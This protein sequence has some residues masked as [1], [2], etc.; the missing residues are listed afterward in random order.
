[1]PY[2]RSSAQRHPRVKPQLSMTTLSL[3]VTKLRFSVAFKIFRKAQ[4]RQGRRA[5][6]LNYM[7]VRLAPFA[8][9]IINCYCIVTAHSKLKFRRRSLASTL[10]CNFYRSFCTLD[11]ISMIW[12]LVCWSSNLPCAYEK[13]RELKRRL[14]KYLDESSYKVF[15][16][17]GEL[18]K[19]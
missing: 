15:I 8:R 10:P 12:I 5:Y 17:F 6:R 13:L 3:L 16:S 7:A 4:E 2:T 18:Y 14:R 11:N 9:L 19:S 1:V